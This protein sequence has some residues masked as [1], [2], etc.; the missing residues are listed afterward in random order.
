MG[1]HSCSLEFQVPIST[2][3]LHI[4]SKKVGYFWILKLENHVS[5]F[6]RSIVIRD[7]Y[8]SFIYQPPLGKQIQ[9]MSGKTPVFVILSAFVLQSSGLELNVVESLGLWKTQLQNHWLLW[10][11]NINKDSP[12]TVP[13]LQSHKRFL[14]FSAKSLLKMGPQ[15][16]H[17]GTHL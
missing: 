16:R 12:A 3:F 5:N 15:S 17:G 4:S 8:A 6:Y 10:W 13:T 11:V 7:L 14:N 1:P 9:P 2:N